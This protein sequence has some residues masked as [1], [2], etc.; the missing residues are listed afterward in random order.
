MLPRLGE[1][2]SAITRGGEWLGRGW[3]RVLRSG[4]SQQGALAREA[5]IKQLRAQIDAL[6][7]TEARSNEA[8]TGLRDKLLEAEQLREDAQRSLY[9]AHRGVSEL[10]GQL[11]GMRGKLDNAQA[12]N[13]AIEAELA[14]LGTSFEDA[15]AQARE[16]RARLGEG[17][18]QDVRPRERAPAAR[19]AAPQP[20]R[21]RARPRATA[22]ARRARTRTSWR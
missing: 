6:T 13:A 8:L 11:Q 3:L 15:Q 5:E 18:R 20:G 2:E 17:R 21:R 22:P 10:A 9:L 1:G 16:S 4:E 14:T 19:P 12:R 7:A